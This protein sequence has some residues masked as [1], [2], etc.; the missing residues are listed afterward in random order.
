MS[1]ARLRKVGGSVMV[2]LPPAALEVAQLSADSVVDVS[3]DASGTI[4]LRPSRKRYSLDE[5]LVGAS[6]DAPLS[7]EDKD[8]LGGPAIGREAI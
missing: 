4:T 5:L 3:V 2:A 8:W 1:L 6:P 7:D